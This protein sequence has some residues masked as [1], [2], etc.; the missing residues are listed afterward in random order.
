MFGVLATGSVL[1][2]GISFFGASSEAE[3]PTPCGTTGTFTSPSQCSYTTTGEDTFTVP[4]GVTS[5]DVVTDGG[6][7]GG[8]EGG[9][10]AQVTADV[11]VTPGDTEYVEVAVSGGSGYDD[12]GDGGGLSGIYSCSSGGTTADCALIVAGG[13]G[14]TGGYGAY[15]SDE[16]GTRDGGGSGTGDLLCNPGDSGTNGAIDGGG[17]YGAGGGTCSAGGYAGASTVGS[18]DAGSAGGPG[19]GGSGGLDSNYWGCGGCLGGGGGGGG[20]GYYGGGGGGSGGYG[21]GAGGGGGSSYA[22]S[23]ASTVSMV[24]DSGT[25]S[26]TITW[27]WPIPI[28]TSLAVSSTNV[29]SGQQVTYTAS[30]SPAPDG[31]TVAFLDG[32][33]NPATS[34]CTAQAVTPTGSSTCTVAYS[35]GGTYDVTATFSGDTDYASS[36]TGSP[37]VITVVPSPPT[38]TGVNPASGSSAGGTKV[39]ITGTNLAGVSKVV[40]GSNIAR[41]FILVSSTKIKVQSPDH[42][43]G[44]VNVRVKTPG[45][46]SVT[47]SSDEYTY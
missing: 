25:P 22:E 28:S 20:G 15:G 43:V 31:G 30:V 3:A 41:H 5:L 47:S 42:T 44:T 45:G 40:F 16:S 8:N 27:T 2:T 6:V 36:S 11:P 17:G 39:I 34:T 21:S 32:A 18:D 37:T 12:G 9:A 23:N 33:G 46:K 10:G 35:E 29:H 19:S 14:G 24:T 4:I 38:V 1:A 7:G 13:G 26:V